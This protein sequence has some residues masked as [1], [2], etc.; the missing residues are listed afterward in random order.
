MKS[1]F[2]L[3]FF[4]SLPYA[5]IIPETNDELSLYTRTP[6]LLRLLKIFRFFKLLRIVKMVSILKR[7][8]DFL[9]TDKFALT[10]YFLTSIVKVIFF[11]HILAC[12]FFGISN[13]ED[14]GWAKL[15]GI[16]DESPGV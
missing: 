2:L 8:E 5:H 12:I 15:S 11:S 9:Y 13:Y 1:W 4:A 16:I 7:Y 6:Q 14:Q 10:T 3:D